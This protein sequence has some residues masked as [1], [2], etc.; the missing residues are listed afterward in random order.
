MPRVIFLTFESAKELARQSVESRWTRIDAS[1][2]TS[3][4]VLSVNG[5]L[6]AEL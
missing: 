3:E 1:R 6:P 5:K 4:V 2:T